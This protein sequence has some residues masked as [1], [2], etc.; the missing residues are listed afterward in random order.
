[1]SLTKNENTVLLGEGV[2]HIHS[3]KKPK[4]HFGEY[5]TLTQMTEM[6]INIGF[7]LSHVGPLLWIFFQTIYK[8]DQFAQN[9]DHM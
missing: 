7:I 4:L 8:H 2:T 3:L 9:L 5:I 1:M 6:P